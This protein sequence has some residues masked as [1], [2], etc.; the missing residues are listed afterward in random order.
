MKIKITELNL[1][2]KYSD[3]RALQF[4]MRSLRP[5]YGVNSDKCNC[6]S[7]RTNCQFIRK[8]LKVTVNDVRISHS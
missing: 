8:K 1:F 5:Y 7:R 3:I 6:Y 4:N 2:N